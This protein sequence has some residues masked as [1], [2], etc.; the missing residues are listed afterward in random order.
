MMP[1]RDA[2]MVMADGHVEVVSRT[3]PNGDVA[4]RFTKNG[5]EVV[6]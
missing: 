3:T 6:P 5:G 2:I 4:A 1:T